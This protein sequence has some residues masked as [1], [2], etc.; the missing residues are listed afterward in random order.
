L[1]LAFGICF[2]HGAPAADPL[3]SYPVDPKL[4][5]VAG[6]SSGAFMANQIHIAHSAGINGLGIKGRH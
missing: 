6:I 1:P 2:S 4:V 3:K 5:S